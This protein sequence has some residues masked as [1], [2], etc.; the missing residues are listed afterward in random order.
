MRTRYISGAV[1]AAVLTA[2]AAAAPATASAVTPDTA[3]AT[4]SAT[5]T[6]PVVTVTSSESYLRYNEVLLEGTAPA[7]ARI[8]INLPG[9]PLTA[10]TTAGSEGDWSYLIDRPLSGAFQGTV[11]TAGSAPTTF[12]LYDAYPEPTHPDAAFRSAVVTSVER[13]GSTTATVAGTSTPG[14]R[15]FI[16]TAGWREGVA[17]ADENGLWSIDMRKATAHEGFFRWSSIWQDH[18]QGEERLD[19][20]PLGA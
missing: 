9:I 2:G 6:T 10:T 15:I 19:F 13:T 8:T 17:I 4:A 7:G 14:G 20:R 3:P 5:T 18:A 11:R 16:Q 12:R 1:L